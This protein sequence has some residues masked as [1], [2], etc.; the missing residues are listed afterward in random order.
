MNHGRVVILLKIGVMEEGGQ[1]QSATVG[2]LDRM[3]YLDQSAYDAKRRQPQ[4]FERSGFRGR[5]E[6]GVQEQWDVS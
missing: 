1:D 4:V 3:T 5:V 6:E 2:K